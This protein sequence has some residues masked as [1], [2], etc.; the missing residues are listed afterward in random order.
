MAN[1]LIRFENGASLQVDVSFT[2]HAAKNE[3]AIKLYGTKGGFEVDPEVVMVKE[4][5]DTIL[6]I[7]PQVDHKSFQFRESFAAEIAHFIECVQEGK[8][9]ISPVEDGVEMMKILNGIYESDR[10]GKDIQL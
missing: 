6:N 4:I 2:L 9:S 5:H 10:L 8:E 1:A 3:Q 7:D